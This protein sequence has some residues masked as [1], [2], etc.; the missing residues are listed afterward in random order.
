LEQGNAQEAVANLEAGKR[1]NP[2]SDYIH[3]QLAL[4]Y[5]RQSRAEDAEREM[6]IYQALKDRHRGRDA[7]PQD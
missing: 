5:R 2:D 3:Y 4:A 7:T 1:L 6:K